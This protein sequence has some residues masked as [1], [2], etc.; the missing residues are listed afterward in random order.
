MRSFDEFSYGGGQQYTP[1]PAS[2][3]FEYIMYHAGYC[4][5]PYCI[6]LCHIPYQ[7]LHVIILYYVISHIYIYIFFI[8]IIFTYIVNGKP[9]HIS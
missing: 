8:Y 9:Y 2:D 7:I 4:V 5:S 6:M 1:Q 3:G